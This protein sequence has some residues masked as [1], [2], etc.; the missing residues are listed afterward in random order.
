[1]IKNYK[2]DLFTIVENLKKEKNAVILAHYYQLPEIQEIADYV[3]DSYGLSKAAK[4]SN[5]DIIVFAGVKFMAETAKILNPKTTVL[6]PEPEAGCSLA[7]SCPALEFEKFIASYPNHIVISYIN[8]SVEVKALSDIICTSS[9]AVQIVES[10]PLETKIIFAPDKNLGRYII[11][12]TGREMV[13]WDGSCHVHNQ[14]HVENVIQM[15]EKYPKAML[16]SHPECQ[17]PIL[18]ISD[19]VGS[20]TQ[21]IDFSQKSQHKEFLVATETGILHE[22]QKKSPEKTF[23]IVPANESCNCND[24][25]FMKMITMEKIYNSLKNNYF[26]ICIDEKI[27]KRAGMPIERMIDIVK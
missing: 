1:M 18:E 16:L 8:C 7:D 3:G 25:N 6:L 17:G 5:A 11:Q 24:C 14:L 22:M 15:K 26:E 4:Q 20:T 19:F 23:Y 21:I 2:N 13:L 9:N 27:A 12:Q 10:L